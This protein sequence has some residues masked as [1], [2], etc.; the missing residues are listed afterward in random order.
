VLVGLVEEAGQIDQQASQGAEAGLASA[1]GWVMWGRAASGVVSRATMVIGWPPQC[2]QSRVAVG[3]SDRPFC[4]A[5][6]PGRSTNQSQDSRSVGR[7]SGQAPWRCRF[8]SSQSEILV[9]GMAS[10]FDCGT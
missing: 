3:P 1:P 9:R 8:P 2:G 6:P 10:S 5:A 4:P 7:K